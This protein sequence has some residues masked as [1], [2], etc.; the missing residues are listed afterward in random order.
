MTIADI[1]TK[2]INEIRE[3]LRRL[4]QTHPMVHIEIKARLRSGY[5]HEIKDQEII[6][7]RG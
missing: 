5:F 7:R 2:N 6:L 3:R 1:V 4:D